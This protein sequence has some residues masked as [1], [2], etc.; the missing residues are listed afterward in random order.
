VYKV[1][2]EFKIGIKVANLFNTPSIEDFAILIAFTLST[3]QNKVKNKEI[4]L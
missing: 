1:N 3:K 2:E 4:I